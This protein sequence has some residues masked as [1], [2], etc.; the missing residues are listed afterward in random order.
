[1]VFFSIG[2]TLTGIPRICESLAA[3]DERNSLPAL[4]TN[5]VGIR[6]CP[7]VVTS[8]RNASRVYGN[9]FLPRVNTPSISNRRPKCG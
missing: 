1:M 2:N 7:E 8:F 5:T 3:F 4:V 6:N 9:N